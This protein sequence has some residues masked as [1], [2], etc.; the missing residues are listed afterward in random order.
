MHDYS[1]NIIV[2][3]LPHCTSTLQYTVIAIV[4]STVIA[5]VGLPHSPLPV[6]AIVG[7]PHSPLLVIAIVGL[8]HL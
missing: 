7:L 2:V 8:P 3:G 4:H 6:I 1:Y 5:I